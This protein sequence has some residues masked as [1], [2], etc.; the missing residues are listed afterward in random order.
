[1]TLTNQPVLQTR[2]T[3]Q[4]QSDGP[5]DLC[6][7]SEDGSLNGSS[8]PKTE[9]ARHPRREQPI[10]PR[11]VTQGPETLAV[12]SSTIDELDHVLTQSPQRGEGTF[13]E[14]RV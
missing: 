12:P 13:F 9:Q 3:K 4:L 6:V 8:R 2:H 7:A 14:A 10:I 5:S 11:R 1:M